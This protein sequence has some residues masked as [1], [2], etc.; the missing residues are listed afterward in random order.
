MTVSNQEILYPNVDI[1]V[2]PNPFK[3]FVN[4][5]IKG[6]GFSNIQFSVLDARGRLIRQENHSNNSFMFYANDLVPGIYFYQIKNQ[7]QWIG[8]GKII[9]E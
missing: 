6:E 7:G 1:A 4:F 9:V 5:E 3:D 8:T 2:F